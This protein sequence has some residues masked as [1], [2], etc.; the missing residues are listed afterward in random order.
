MTKSYN[1]IPTHFIYSSLLFFL[2]IFMYQLIRCHALLQ[3]FFKIFL[4]RIYVPTTYTH[5]PCL[6]LI[7]TRPARRLPQIPTP[8]RPRKPIHQRHRP[9]YL[10]ASQSTT[11]NSTSTQTKQPQTHA[12]TLPRKPNDHRHRAKPPPQ[13]NTRRLPAPDVD[14]DADAP[15]LT[16][17]PPVPYPCNWTGQADR[18]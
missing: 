14:V 9:P 18:P 17:P 5:R 12:P 3:P 7:P 11:T 13:I 1:Y 2:L 10:H 15:T 6:T 16:Q 8:I 4:F